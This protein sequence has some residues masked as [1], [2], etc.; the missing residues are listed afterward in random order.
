M[1]LML[2]AT[3]MVVSSCDKEDDDDDNN[4]PGTQTVVLAGEINSDRTLSSDTI[5]KL[6]GYVVVNSG[7]TLN[8]EAGTI[9]KAELGTG[10]DASVLVIT[11]GAKINAVGTAANPIVF[12][13][14]EDS[15]TVGQKFG[16]NLTK[17]DISLWGGIIILGNAKVSAANGDTEAQ[18]EGLPANSTFGVY[19][20]S[21]DADDSGNF[22]YV[23]IRHT[24]TAI[25]DDNELQGLT[26]GGVGTATDISNVEVYASFDDGIE[27]FGGAVSLSNV[28][29][30]YANDDALDFDQNYSGTITNFYVIHEGGSGGNAAFEFDGPEGT[31]HTT[32]KFTVTNGT[33]KSLNSG[34]GRAGTL[35]SSA[36]GTINNTEFIDFTSWI[37]VEGGSAITKFIAGD[38][39]ITNS[40]FDKSSL[41]GAVKPVKV[42]GTTGVSTLTPADSLAVIAAFEL[43]A[44]NNTATTSPTVGATINTFIGWTKADD[45]DLVD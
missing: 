34:L 43:V 4:N 29:I 33:V 41:S 18:I 25:D 21:N 9:I 15:I 14:V 22:Q 20:G 35:K 40:Q 3:S 30:A 38:L 12:T 28:L 5:Y 23:S 17:N 39:K 10:T 2:V 36:Q 37:N 42:D 32:G 16:T 45:E 11:R 26:L 31:T 24:G 1:L 7:V 8:I 27:I 44:N 19:G 6:D 13:S